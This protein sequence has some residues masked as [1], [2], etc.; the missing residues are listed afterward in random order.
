VRIL[1]TGATGSAGSGALRAAIADPA[2]EGITVLA[3]R[4]PKESSEKILFVQHDDFLRYDHVQGSLGGHDA[5]LW[6]LG[7]SQSR[8][9]R[10]SLHRITVEFVVAGA[11]AFMKANPDLQFCHLSGGGADPTGK[12]RMPF[13]QEKGQAELA[14][15][16]LGLAG[17]WHFR[18]GY[19][20]PKEPVEKPLMQ[21]RLM[22]MLEPVFRKVVPFGMVDA[23]DLGRAMLKVAAE[24]HPKHVLENRDIR[25]LA[26]LTTGV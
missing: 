6:C 4:A 13:A 7:T 5:A 12:S 1:L 3:R 21:D 11:T 8:V 15:D 9:D 2:V 24:G 16:G 18:P 14:L 20:H 19:I 10:A 26:G 17:L 23:D 22:W 25:K